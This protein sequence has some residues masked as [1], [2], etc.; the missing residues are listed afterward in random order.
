[1]KKQAMTKEIKISFKLHIISKKYSFILNN[2]Y[3]VNINITNSK[4]YTLF[5]IKAF[6]EVITIVH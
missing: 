2:N 3:C 6:S 5:F 1:M 4:I